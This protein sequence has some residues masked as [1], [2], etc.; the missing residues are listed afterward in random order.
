MTSEPLGQIIPRVIQNIE[1]KDKGFDIFIAWERAAGKRI[2]R[3]T[4]P[5]CFQEGVLV[6]NVD[7]AGWF[8]EL[9]LLKP[10]LIK[11]LKKMLSPKPLEGLKFQIG[12]V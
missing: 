11:K 8:Y 12:K 5:V 2:S 3:H 1:K 6:V 10:F 4:K 9:N 7:K